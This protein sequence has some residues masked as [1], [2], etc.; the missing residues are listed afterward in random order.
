MTVGEEG[1]GVG[2]GASPGSCASPN[3]SPGPGANPSPDVSPGSI[4]MVRPIPTPGSNCTTGGIGG[5]D[6][7]TNGKNDR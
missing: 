7:E 6:N 4:C 3:L 2:V 1:V 5:G